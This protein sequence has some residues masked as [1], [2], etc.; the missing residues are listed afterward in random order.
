MLRVGEVDL[1]FV[2]KAAREGGRPPEVR[3]RAAL[4]SATGLSDLEEPV[5]LGLSR[6]SLAA[7]RSRVIVGHVLRGGRHCVICERRQCFTH[8]IGSQS[9]DD[10][11]IGIPK[12]LMNRTT[13]LLALV[14][15]KEN[16][17][18]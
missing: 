18:V 13:S 3:E 10:N 8:R 1:S 11:S 9:H 12:C 2:P 16:G 6:Q 7:A 4:S 5:D 14:H 15:D 17:R